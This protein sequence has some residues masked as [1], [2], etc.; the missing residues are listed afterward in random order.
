SARGSGRGGGAAAG[1]VAGV[2]SRRTGAGG[3]G[4]GVG[5]VSI[6]GGGGGGEIGAG[7][8]RSGGVS[9]KPEARSTRG[10][11]VSSGGGGCSTRG[12]RGSARGGG[13]T[14]RETGGTT[15]TGG[16][17]G[18]AGSPVAAFTCPDFRSIFRSAQ[19]SA[20]CT[21]FGRI[22]PDL[23]PEA[24]V[25]DSLLAGV[26]EAGV[27]EKAPEAGVRRCTVV[28]VAVSMD[29]YGMRVHFIPDCARLSSRRKAWASTGRS[30]TSLASSLSTSASTAGFS[31][32]S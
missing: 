26:T 30:F 9:A 19:R 5:R 6:N 18:L 17:V 8:T 20:S 11:T 2:G 25:C 10:R 32:N 24:G 14:G 16:A 15:G 27:E 4:A 12:T 31:A 28:G 22:S 7:A 23:S 29:S 3:G 13:G 1:R 21:Y